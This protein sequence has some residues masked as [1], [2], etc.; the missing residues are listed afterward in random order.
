MNSEKRLL[1]L[2]TELSALKE[3]LAVNDLTTS[4]ILVQL[5]K[6]ISKIEKRLGTQL[7]QG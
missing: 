6:A 2:E 3:R 1:A 7:P 5:Q 4:Q